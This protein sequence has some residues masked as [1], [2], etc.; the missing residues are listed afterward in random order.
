MEYIE[1]SNFKTHRRALRAKWLT[2]QRRNS[3]W[4]GNKNGCSH[5]MSRDGW[6]A[7]LEISTGSSYVVAEEATHDLNN[8]WDRHQY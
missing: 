2:S 8:P 1:F 4:T 3:W 5:R 7:L 6:E